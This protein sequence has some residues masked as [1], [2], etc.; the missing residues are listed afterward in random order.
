MIRK[1]KKFLSDWIG[2]DIYII[3]VWKIPIIVFVAVILIVC[4]KITIEKRWVELFTYH[5][6]EYKALENEA[7][8]MVENQTFNTAY[9]CIIKSLDNRNDNV[10]FELKSESAAID[11]KVTDYKKDTQKIETERIITSKE[12]NIFIVISLIF[13]IIPFGFAL[14][15]SV[16]LGILYCIV[17]GIIFLFGFIMDKLEK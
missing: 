5:E 7:R 9:H 11:V 1:V 13:I 6:E 4:G 2:E 14:C 10:S 16:S 12:Q 17:S 15:V 8:L 3:C